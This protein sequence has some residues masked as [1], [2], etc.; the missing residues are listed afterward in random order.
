MAKFKFKFDAVN[1]VKQNLEKRVMRDLALINIEI[2]NISIEIENLFTEKQK[3]REASLSNSRIKANELQARLNYE[4][5]LDEII[6]I[7]MDRKVSMEIEKGKIIEELAQKKK[8]VKIFDSLKEK[9]FQKY[10]AEQNKNE[11]LLLD[12]MAAKKFSNA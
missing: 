12:E 3:V 11:L 6:K 4:N 5:F 2:N 10:I 8:E 1:K 9:H 7:K